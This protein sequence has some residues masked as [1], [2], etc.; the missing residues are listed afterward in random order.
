MP[1]QDMHNVFACAFGQ[2]TLMK[3][4]GESFVPCGGSG[5]AVGARLLASGTSTLV[6]MPV[7]A[8]EGYAQTPNPASR[9]QCRLQDPKNALSICKLVLVQVIT[10]QPISTQ[11]RSCKHL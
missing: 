8:V 3:L 9:L 5:K 6:L 7:N 10:T 11:G 2:H 1:A 4:V